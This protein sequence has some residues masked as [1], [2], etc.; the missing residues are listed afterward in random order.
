MD[1]SV[2]QII[3][4]G[5]PG[6]RGSHFGICLHRTADPRYQHVSVARARL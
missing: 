2:I 3:L 6:L 5:S 1:A 4:S